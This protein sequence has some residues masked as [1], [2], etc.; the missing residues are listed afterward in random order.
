MNPIKKAA[1]RLHQA[2]VPVKGV[3]VYPDIGPDVSPPAAVIGPPALTWEGLPGCGGEP[4]S[5]RFGVWVVVDDDDRSVSRLI[6]LVPPVAAALDAVD[7]AV[8]VRADPTTYPGS[9]KDLPAYQIQV[10]MALGG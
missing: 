10:D 7:D 6:E 3:R 2:L 4:T 5:G 1:E 9:S 8:V